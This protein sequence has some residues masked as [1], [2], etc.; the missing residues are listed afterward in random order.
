MLSG[1]PKNF[2]KEFSTENSMMRAVSPRLEQRTLSKSPFRKTLS[3]SGLLRLADGCFER[4]AD[5]PSSRGL[6][7]ADCRMSALVMF[8]LKCPPLLRFDWD[9]CGDERIR[10]NLKALCGVL[11]TPS[12]TAVRERLDAVDPCTLGRAF[13]AAFTALQRGKG[14]ES[15]RKRMA[16]RPWVG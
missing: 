9:A 1:G 10:L 13:K 4:I 16:C 11:R 6:N 14:L 12:D 5:F 2:F 8:G 7:L 3:A 15:F